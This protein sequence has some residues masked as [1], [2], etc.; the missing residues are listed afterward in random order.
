MHGR[1]IGKLLLGQPPFSPCLLHSQAYP[2]PH[3]H[4]AENNLLKCCRP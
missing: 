3:I 4:A 1:A 2:R